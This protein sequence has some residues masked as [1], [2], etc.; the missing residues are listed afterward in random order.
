MASKT[1]RY[2]HHVLNAGP[3]ARDA[4]FSSRLADLFS[5]SRRNTSSYRQNRRIGVSRA[6]QTPRETEKRRNI[7][8]S[9]R[10]GLRIETLRREGL[11]A[12]SNIRFRERTE[13]R[14][15]RGLRARTSPQRSRGSLPGHGST[16]LP[17]PARRTR[18]R[19]RAPG[20]WIERS[21]RVST[22]GRFATSTLPRARAPAYRLRVQAPWHGA[23]CSHLRSRR[24]SRERARG[25]CCSV[26]REKAR[27]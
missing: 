25:R 15:P 1:E 2:G 19:S 3:Y 10:Y 20:R 21:R 14:A 5:G 18:A 9:S 6:G 23:T 4:P 27:P 8:R 22:R 26:P 11:T 16:L 13:R 24:R 7:R 12:A 17:P